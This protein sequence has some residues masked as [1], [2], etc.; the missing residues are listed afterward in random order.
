[1]WSIDPTEFSVLAVDDDEAGLEAMFRDL[2]AAGFR[3]LG[4]LDSPKALDFLAK[5][6]AGEAPDLA[7]ARR[8]NVGPGVEFQA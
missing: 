1:M 4:F 3:V 2:S 6:A 5:C 7:L 8:G